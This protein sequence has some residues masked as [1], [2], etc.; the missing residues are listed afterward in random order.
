MDISWNV[1]VPFQTSILPNNYVSTT[2]FSVIFAT[3]NSLRLQRKLC[4]VIDTWLITLTDFVAH[5]ISDYITSETG[6]TVIFESAIVPKWK[7]SRI[8]FKNVYIS[9][10]PGNTSPQSFGSASEHLAA[11]GYD[12]SNHPANHLRDDEDTTSHPGVADDQNVSMFDLTVDSIDVTLSV[13]R[14]LDGK[15]LVKDAVIKGVRGILGI[16]LSVSSYPSSVFRSDRQ[17]VRW[18]ENLNP[19]DFRHAHQP[20]DFELESLQLEDILI[21]VYQP[22]GFRPY[23]ASIFH[24]DIKCL[25]KQW[26]FYDFLC[27]EN[28]VGQFDNCLFSLHKPQ[29][30]GRTTES[31]LK[32][33]EW[34]RMVCFFCYAHP[35]P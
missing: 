19:A 1:S 14:W 3:A 31:D 22:D 9:R 10:R 4:S 23:T 7:D 34:A 18:D 35:I 6:V 2:F 21:T 25:R 16:H 33:G 20:G 17:S 15:G 32:D 11:V 5:F 8:S 29:S 28:I 26:L 13:W 24:A 12:V 27:A 30:I